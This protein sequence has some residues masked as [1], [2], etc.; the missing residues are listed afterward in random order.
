MI[1]AKQES[2]KIAVVTV[3]DNRREG[4]MEENAQNFY[5]L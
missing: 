1:T 5:C 3:I 2:S 4:G